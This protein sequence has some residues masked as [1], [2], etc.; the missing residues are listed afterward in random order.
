MALLVDLDIQPRVNGVVRYLA[1]A[2][3][4]PNQRERYQLSFEA[5]FTNNGRREVKL[6]KLEYSFPTAPALGVHEIVLKTLLRNEDPIIVRLGLILGPGASHAPMDFKNTDN[7]IL[8]DPPPETIRFEVFADGI[9][10]TA[11][12]D[13][14]LA[15]HESPVADGAYRWMANAH[16]LRHGEYW[17]GIGAEHCCGH[18][19]YAHDLGVEC[20]DA[21]IWTS[22]L[23]QKNN[24]HN[25]HYRVWEKPIYA[26][27]DGKVKAFEND[28]DDNT[29]PPNLPTHDPPTYGNHFI[30]QHGTDKMLYAHFKK[31][32]LNAELMRRGAEVKAGDFLGLVGNSGNSSQPH[33]HIHCVD[34]TNNTLRPIPWKQKMVAQKVFNTR[35]EGT[36]WVLSQRQGL[37]VVRNVIYPGD[38]PPADEREWSGWNALGGEL[39]FGPCV[40]SWSENRL[41]VFA[42]STDRALYHKYWNGQRWSDWE[43]L[44]G[45]LTAKP[46]AVSW[47]RN[48]IDVF[49]RAIDNSLYHKWWDGSRWHEWEGLGGTLLSGPAVC[50]RRQNHLDV[51]VV[52]TDRSLY[53][54]IW[55]GSN[56]TSWETLGGTLTADP[57]AVS[58]DNNRID[59]FGRATDETL[60]QKWW[61]GSSWSNWEARGRAMLYGPAV[62][63]RKANHLDVFLV[64]PDSTLQHTIWTGTKWSFWESLG[65]SLTADPAAVS[66]SSKRIDV[67]GRAIDNSLYHKSWVPS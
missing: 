22:L 14:S 63:S 28:I 40:S 36:D 12:F 47:G 33:L 51:F 53:H 19:L 24:Q 8:M 23:P 17:E 45:E 3:S 59:V 66:W 43:G 64:A 48:R 32:T 62:G 41:D 42:V 9:D 67:F 10:D 11:V 37:S 52:A 4:N 39:I 50:S 18:Q 35:T 5:R 20:F 7:K 29:N 21:G 58:W 13:H 25:E 57:A 30:V 46:A 26:M 2:P 56:W 31:G 34:E 38:A 16:E 6:M 27:A 61:D 60:Y 15:R 49:G 65:G 55:N 44:G 54:R 1:L